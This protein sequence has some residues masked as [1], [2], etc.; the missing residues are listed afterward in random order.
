LLITLSISFMP[1][2]R[3]PMCRSAEQKA[4]LH[5][6]HGEAAAAVADVED[7]AALRSQRSCPD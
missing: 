4:L 2:F 6:G 5:S 1:V 3:L 7:D